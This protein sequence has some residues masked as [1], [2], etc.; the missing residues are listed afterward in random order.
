L[1]LRH[2]KEIFYYIKGKIKEGEKEEE[3]EIDI[4]IPLTILKDVLGNSC[5]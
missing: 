2:L 5:K 4:K 3:V 1:L